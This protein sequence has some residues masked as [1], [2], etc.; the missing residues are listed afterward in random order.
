[1]SK[2][3]VELKLSRGVLPLLTVVIN[4]AFGVFVCNIE[5]LQS[6]DD[7]FHSVLGGVIWLDHL[8]GFEEM[9]E[10]IDWSVLVT[11]DDVEL[12]HV[13]FIMI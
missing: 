1:M 7:S 13:E 9:F 11:P 6:T 8:V 3:V 10:R 2:L 12:L 5:T 4:H